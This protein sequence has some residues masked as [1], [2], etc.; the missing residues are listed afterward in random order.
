MHA[1]GQE[2]IGGW[3][4]CRDKIQQVRHAEDLAKDIRDENQQYLPMQYENS[5]LSLI[6]SCKEELPNLSPRL[7]AST[8]EQ[9]L[10]SKKLYA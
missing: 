7:K 3:P 10:K 9:Q 8:L 4:R 1:D 5:S 2:A 6:D